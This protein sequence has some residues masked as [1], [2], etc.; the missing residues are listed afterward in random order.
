VSKS[1]KEILRQELRTRREAFVASLTPEQLLQSWI[2]LAAI[3]VPHVAPFKTIAS[4]SATGSETNPCFIT[5][6]LQKYAGISLPRVVGNAAALTFH[7]ILNQTTLIPG[8]AKI[9]EPPKTA[10]P[11]RPDIVLVPL[12]G[13]D[14]LGSRLGQGQGHYDITIAALRAR[15]PIF[16]LGLAYDCQLVDQIPAEPHDQRLD[17]LVTESRFLRFAP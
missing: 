8:Y 11:A 13:V 5:G 7:T 9:P 12:V 10:A 4:Y 16:V 6:A 2:N 3:A 1:P 15:S 17:A 14:R